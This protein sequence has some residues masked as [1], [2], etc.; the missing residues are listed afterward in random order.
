MCP[1][2]SAPS[3]LPAPRISR[4][5][6]AILNPLPSAWCWEI[7]ASR[8]CA[9]SRHLAMRREE[10]VGERALGA[11]ADPAAELVEL[12]EPEQ[13]G[14]VD[15]E[16]VRVRHVETRLDDRRADEHVGLALPEPRSSARSSCVL[17]HL[18][19]RDDDRAPRGA[20][21][22]ACRPAGRSWRRGCGPRTPDP[23]GAARAGPPR[24]RAPRRTEP[25]KVRTGWRSSG[26]VSIVLIVAD[27]GERH[28]ERARDRRRRHR[29]HVDLRPHRLQPLLVRDAEALLLVDDEQTEIGEL[30]VPA[31]QPVGAD[32]DVDLAGGEV[33]DHS[34]AARR[35]TESRQHPHRHG[36]RARTARGTSGSAARRA[37]S[38]ARAPRPACRPSRP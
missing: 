37:A 8:R 35:S 14:A 7:V 20:A 10:E 18:P 3:R 22:A 13:V 15:D 28:L 27:P 24:P 9:S 31:E 5:R 11:T 33:L 1:L 16:R 34:V 2:C 29:Q 21:P 6:S 25:T 23:R 4:S 19:V 12:R 26:G 32:H 30:H 36:E 38:S 17:V